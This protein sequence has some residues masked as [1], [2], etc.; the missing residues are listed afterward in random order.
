MMFVPFCSRCIK[1]SFS[2]HITFESVLDEDRR[3]SM[4]S[5]TTYKDILML[6][7]EEIKH[8]RSKKEVASEVVSKDEVKSI[9]MHFV[10]SKHYKSSKFVAYV[11]LIHKIQCLDI[12]LEAF[13][14]IL[15]RIDKF[16]YIYCLSVQ[17]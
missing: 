4:L 5:D 10:T 17:S 9:S 3:L 8:F 2:R 13:V 12:F 16:C 7:S 11:N 14:H 1:S 15:K 6:Q